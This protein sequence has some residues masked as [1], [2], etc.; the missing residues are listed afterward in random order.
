M[1]EAT[2]YRNLLDF[3]FNT[4][5]NAINELRK[6][7]NSSS[8]NQLQ[9]QL[10]LSILHLTNAKNNFKKLYSENSNLLENEVQ[11]SQNPD[12]NPFV[13]KL[14]LQNYNNLLKIDQLNNLINSIPQIKEFTNLPI[15]IRTPNLNFENLEDSSSVLISQDE[16]SNLIDKLIESDKLK[17]KLVQLHDKVYESQ[18]QRLNESL[19]KW[20]GEL[21][22]ITEFINN[23][24]HFKS[25]LQNK[26]TSDQ[27]LTDVKVDDTNENS[28]V[29]DLSDPDA[30]D[31][32]TS[33][34]SDYDIA[35]VD[36]VIDYEN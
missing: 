3:S 27:N 12:K 33:N 21:A 15:Q 1:N 34:T 10:T 6:S 31:A 23:S 8:L 36:D 19:V 35:N 7:P 2:E 11:I 4:T 29:T 20:N 17:F 9:H 13:L 25:Q 28:S 26:L 22:T 5:L 18:I 24:T 16:M 32:D 30:S 14:E